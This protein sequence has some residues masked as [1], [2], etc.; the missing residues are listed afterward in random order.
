MKKL[1]P[2]LLLAFFSSGLVAQEGFKIGL[3]GGI[4]IGDFDDQLSLV[5]AADVGYMWALSEV[6]DLGIASGFINGFTDKFDTG[7]EL[8]DLPNV[9]FIP[10]AASVRI[11]PTNSFTLG[12]EGG[13]ALGISDG[14]DGGAYVRPLIGYLFGTFTELNLSYTYISLDGAN[15]SS[16]TVGLLFTIPSKNRLSRFRS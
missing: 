6:V 11:W 5:I 2:V 1:L 3:Q 4:P 14:N 12:A 9:Q 15:W 8:I 13:Y 7:S 16:V 10:A